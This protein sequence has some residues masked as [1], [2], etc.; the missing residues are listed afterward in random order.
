MEPIK[1]LLFISGFEELS[2]GYW[3]RQHKYKVYLMAYN[4]SFYHKKVKN[5]SLVCTFD[6][7]KELKITLDNFGLLT[8]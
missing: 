2:P 8:I 3:Q 5:W 7:Y 4:N 6:T 1:A